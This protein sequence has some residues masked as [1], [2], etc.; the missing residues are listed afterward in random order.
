MLW[1]FAY[2]FFTSVLCTGTPCTFINIWA[3][4]FCYW[5]CCWCVCSLSALYTWYFIIYSNLFDQLSN[6]LLW[7]CMRINKQTHVYVPYINIHP[8]PYTCRGCI[9]THTRIKKRKSKA[10]KLND[11]GLCVL[12]WWSIVVY[13]CIVCLF[14]CFLVCL[15][16]YERREK[17]H[18]YILI[19]L[20]LNSITENKSNIVY[21]Y[22]SR[23]HLCA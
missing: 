14:V 12:V 2:F 8:S 21:T 3:N 10:F 1:I 22:K 9:H 4:H 19:I 18:T 6:L 16:A 20:L 17:N 7:W 5:C 23:Q 15:Y 13:V 11:I